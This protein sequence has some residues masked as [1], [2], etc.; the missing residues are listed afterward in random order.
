MR[1]WTL[2]VEQT[3]FA[4]STLLVLSCS[5]ARSTKRKESLIDSVVPGNSKIR[6]TLQV[7]VAARDKIPNRSSLSQL[8]VELYRAAVPAVHDP[9]R[10]RPGL[11]LHVVTVS[12]WPSFQVY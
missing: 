11:A 7:G 3:V 5:S 10:I 8:R 9:G 4:P 2:N 1:V 12:R 6:Q